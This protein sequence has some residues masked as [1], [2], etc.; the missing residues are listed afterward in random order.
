[1]LRKVL[2]LPQFDESGASSRIRVYNL[3]PFFKE[4]DIE[5]VVLPLLTNDSNLLLNELA[6]KGKLLRKF[7][8]LI[9][10]C[11]TF[12]KRIHHVWNAKKYDLVVV[13]KDVLPFGLA[14]LLKYRQ[15]KIV[16]DIDDA[17]WEGHSSAGDYSWLTFMLV[18]YR[19]A[20]LL[21]MLKV[22]VAVI[23]DNKYL[24]AFAEDYNPSV[25]MLSAPIDS[26]FYSLSKKSGSLKNPVKTIGWIGSPGTTYLLEAILPFLEKLSDQNEFV[27]HNVGGFPLFSNKFNIMNINW[28]LENELKSLA[29]MDLGLMP[30]DA[31]PFNKGKLGYKIVQYFCAGV[32]TLGTDIALNP[33]VIN[34]ENGALYS[35]GDEEDFV[36]KALSILTD[37][38]KAKLLGE[39][40]RVLAE[41]KYDLKIQAKK[42]ISDLGQ[43]V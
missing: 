33:E 16:Y 8:I 22:S 39:H 36:A 7:F 37:P 43:L 20:L 30:L 25:L 38:K 23:V 9:K 12:L 1:L 3:L 14:L 34:D 18:A 19:K 42:L 41:T 29:Q 11:F 28:S 27:L 32:P 26:S 21:R 24:K 15:K 2:F 40:A 35:L 10:T 6:T 17:I 5:T 4:A 31:S 13:Q